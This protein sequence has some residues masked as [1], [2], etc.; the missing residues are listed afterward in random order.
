MSCHH[1]NGCWDH[2]SKPSSGFFP[3]PRPLP[4]LDDANDKPDGFVIDVVEWELGADLVL[5]P[6]HPTHPA[7]SFHGI[8]IYPR[9]H[10]SCRA[11]CVLL[12]RGLSVIGMPC[13]E[14]R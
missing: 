8:S 14:V 11:H 1:A 3:L 2:V 13:P 9:L 10:E 12:D 4:H 5:F 7:R 6:H